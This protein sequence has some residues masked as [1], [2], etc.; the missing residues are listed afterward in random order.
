V[1]VNEGI[2]VEHRP[3]QRKEARQGR[4]G[5]QG[6]HQQRAHGEP[7]SSQ[8]RGDGHPGHLLAVALQL[9]FVFGQAWQLP[10]RGLLL[11]ALSGVVGIALGDSLFFA[12]L[13]RLGTR[14]AL[15][16]DAGGPAFTTLAGANRFS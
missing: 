5:A 2:A 12:A 8:D 7:E 16:N 3:P 15:T 9:P 4:Q 14:R 10:P 6:Q 11:L 13:R 1:R